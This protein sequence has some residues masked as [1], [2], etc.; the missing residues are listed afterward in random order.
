[1]PDPNQTVTA[2]DFDK[3]PIKIKLADLK[4]RP[5]AYSV[6][7]KDNKILLLK[8]INGYDLP[9]GGIEIGETP[10]EAAIREIQEETGLIAKN[11]KLIDCGTQY[12]KGYRSTNFYQAIAIYYT[13]EIAGGELSNDG[14]DESEKEFVEKPVWL[15]ISEIDNIECGGYRDFKDVVK[16]VI[17][18]NHRH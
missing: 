10:E 2:Y 1:M 13:C 6:I 8:Q 3:T 16:K 5:A 9:G 17:N 18:E 7:I 14:F 4:W 12:F 11:P 15:D